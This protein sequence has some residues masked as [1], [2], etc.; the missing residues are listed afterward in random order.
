MTHIV[1]YEHHYKPPPKKKPKAAAIEV[2]A[3][4]KVTDPKLVRAQ[5]Q[6]RAAE[7]DTDPEKTAAMRAWLKNA[8]VRGPSG[9]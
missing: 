7:T 8:M 3:I 9:T 6:E 2:P 5:R 1:T 4:V